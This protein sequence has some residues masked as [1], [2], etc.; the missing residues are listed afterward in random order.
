MCICGWYDPYQLDRRSLLRVISV[1]LRPPWA[2]ARQRG[3]LVMTLSAA[4][5]LSSSAARSGPST[6][7]WVSVSMIQRQ[8]T[9]SRAILRRSAS[10]TTAR[11]CEPSLSERRH[12][13]RGQSLSLQ[14]L[15]LLRVIYCP[16]VAVWRSNMGCVPQV[17]TLS[18]RAAQ[19]AASGP[20]TRQAAAWYASAR[21][22][23]SRRCCRQG[24]T[25]PVKDTSCNVVGPCKFWAPVVYS[26]CKEFAPLSVVFW[27]V[28]Q[29]HYTT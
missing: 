25:R 12:W 29:P 9:R 5:I 15:A 23:A 7:R 10:A 24:R 4:C 6:L 28:S 13:Q 17:C 11:H 20:D 18:A 3:D 14:K 2:A 22:S 21:S 16:S 27:S 26:V 19:A 1:I 8:D